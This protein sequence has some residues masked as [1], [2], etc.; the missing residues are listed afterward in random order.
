MV[1]LADAV[2][3]GF[4]PGPSSGQALA[5]IFSGKVNPSGRL[6]ITYPRYDDGGGIPYFHA[7]SDQCT[8]GSGT[9]PHWDSVPCEVQWPFGHGLSYTTYEYSD[10]M[11]TGGRGE[12]LI[13]SVKVKNTG[14]AA[15]SE[16]VMFFTFDKY[17][18]TTP[19]YKRLRAFEKIHLEAGQEETVTKTVPADDLKFI[20]P[21]DDKH[22]ISD[23]D[24]SFLVGV[25]A[26]TDCRTN[27]D[28]SLCA[29]AAPVQDEQKD[30]YV[31]A[32]DAACDVWVHSG[33]ADNFQMSQDACWNMC[34]SVS[35]YPASTAD[36]VNDGWGW[37]YVSCLESVVWG[38]EQEKG[39]NQCWRMTSLCRDV[40]RT[41]QMD[42]YGIG[43]GGSG[44]SPSN[45]QGGT[46]PVGNIVAIFS[47]LIAAILIFYTMRGGTFTT[48]RREDS[49][50][51]AVQFSPVGTAVD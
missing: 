32:C 1:E 19:E 40:F 34:V 51:G 47:G 22:Y 49:D 44:H 39:P 16:T 3:V 27:P 36:K 17:R 14:S 28:S 4:L 18:S 7:V 37:N 26:S 38:M 29:E 6:P 43:P 46:P 35:R 15:G 48:K 50:R 12:D 42:E 33:C 41:G 24:L 23:P 25:G 9:L 21:H 45:T 10:L 20:G 30:D 5:D 8:S 2:V 11:V 31:G 13:V